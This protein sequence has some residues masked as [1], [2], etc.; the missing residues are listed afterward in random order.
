MCAAGIHLRDE[1]ADATLPKGL[2]RKTHCKAKDFHLL[3]YSVLTVCLAC[4]ID[5]TSQAK[6][7]KLKRRLLEA[8]PNL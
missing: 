4:V 2:K 1:D 8:I 6:F 5:D 3:L 7:T